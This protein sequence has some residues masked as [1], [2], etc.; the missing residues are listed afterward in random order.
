MSLYLEI[1]FFKQFKA[2][3]GIILFKPKK[4]KEEE[5]LPHISSGDNVPK[6]PIQ[7]IRDH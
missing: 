4:L 1:I 5:S 6:K 7:K 2:F 3:I